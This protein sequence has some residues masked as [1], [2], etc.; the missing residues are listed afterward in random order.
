MKYMTILMIVA[1]LT[2]SACDKGPGPVIE[3]NPLIGGWSGMAVATWPGDADQPVTDS[4][5]IS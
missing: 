5:L 1:L 4:G 3:S 2:L